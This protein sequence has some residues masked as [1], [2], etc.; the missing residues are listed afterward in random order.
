MVSTRTQRT[1]D[2]AMARS[3]RPLRYLAGFVLNTGMGIFF[4]VAAHT[5]TTVRDAT[6][7]SFGDL[8]RRWPMASLG[9]LA[10]CGRTQLDGAAVAAQILRKRLFASIVVQVAPPRRSAWP[11]P[12]PPDQSVPKGSSVV[13]P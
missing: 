3:A 12:S 6:A 1:L 5:T 4:A 7:V 8:R 11:I 2:D 9:L 13:C 10:S